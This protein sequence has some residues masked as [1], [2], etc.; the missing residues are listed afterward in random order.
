MKRLLFFCLAVVFMSSCK[1][2]IIEKPTSLKILENVKAALK[3]SISP[4]DYQSLDFHRALFSKADQP[5]LYF[6]RV[7]FKGKKIS[8]HF[9][10]VK[11]DKDG[12]IESGRIIQL[13]LEPVNPNGTIIVYSLK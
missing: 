1:K 8:E 2:E 5:Q 12:L 13:T 11:T 4:S 6:L 3:D 10:I 7:P 9:V